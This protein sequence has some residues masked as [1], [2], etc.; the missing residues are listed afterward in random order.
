VEGFNAMLFNGNQDI[1]TALKKG[2]NVRV[3]TEA[4]ENPQAI[5]GM[6]KDLEHPLLNIKYISP[7]APICMIIFDDK[8]VH[9]RMS[10][11]AVP[12]FWSNNSN[13]V[14][15]SRRYFNELWNKL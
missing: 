13:I 9:L 4:P 15:L 11:D 7:P 6:I 14:T 2:V 12:S 10:E 8:E 3:M 5:E 1:K